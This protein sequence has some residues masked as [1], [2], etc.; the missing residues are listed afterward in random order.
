MKERDPES[1][2]LYKDLED[3]KGFLVEQQAAILCDTQRQ[4]KDMFSPLIVDI[5]RR[6]I[7]NEKDNR[8]DHENFEKRISNLEGR[9]KIYTWFQRHG[10]K[11]YVISVLIFIAILIYFGTT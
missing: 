4:M 7:V 1:P 3:L 2:L 9:D 8:E 10:F 6:V 11:T 5:Q